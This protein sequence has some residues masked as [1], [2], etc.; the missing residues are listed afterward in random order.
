VAN[1]MPELPPNTTMR[2]PL[3]VMAHS[4]L[5]LLSETHVRVCDFR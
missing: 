4:S 5:L 1:P 3:R 2:C